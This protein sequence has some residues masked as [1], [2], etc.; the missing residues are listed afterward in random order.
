MVPAISTKL[1]YDYASSLQAEL[2]L[3]KD[4]TL[5]GF[6]SWVIDWKQSRAVWEIPGKQKPWNRI[7]ECEEMI[8]RRNLPVVYYFTCNPES[9]KPIYES[10]IV[11]KAKDTHNISSIPDNFKGGNC[12]YVGSR[13][14]GVHGRMIQH[15]GFAEKCGV[16]ALYLYHVTK[17]MR[18][19]PT[20]TFHYATLLPKYRNLTKHI[21]AVLQDELKPFIGKRSIEKMDKLL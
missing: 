10:F 8:S 13:K 3:L 2:E 7:K 11:Q 16:G 15:L 9:A 20:I 17:N 21:E 5:P 18:F 1:F 19:I 12:I 14:N 4:F 6:E